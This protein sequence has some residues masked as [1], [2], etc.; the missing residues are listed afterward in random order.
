M[1]ARELEADHVMLCNKCQ[2]PASDAVVGIDGEPY[3][4]NCGQS[5]AMFD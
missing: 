3:H 5:L 2:K 1:Q 4:R